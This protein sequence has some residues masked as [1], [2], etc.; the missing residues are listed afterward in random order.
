MTF[1]NY[2]IDVVIPL[3]NCTKIV[4]ELIMRISR[5]AQD[6]GLLINLI[7]IDDGSSDDTWNRVTNSRENAGIIIFAMKLS[8]NFGQ[9]SAILSGLL[10][11]TRQCVILMDG[12]LQDKPE[13]IPRFVNKFLEEGLDVVTGVLASNNNGLTSR[14][15]ASNI[16][17]RLRGKSG[18]ETSFRA[19]SNR[20]KVALLSEPETS[21]LSGPVIDSI[22]F[23]QGVLDIER[24]ERVHGTRYTLG[25]KLDL[26]VNF[27]LVKSRRAAYLFL[28]LAG[29]TG[30][31]SL[32]Y[33]STLMFQVVFLSKGLPAGL[34]QVVLLL[35][36]QMTFLSLGIAILILL[37]L[38]TLKFAT[39]A[40]DFH[41]M[42]TWKNH[43]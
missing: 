1:K 24:G 28:F 13:D 21:E 27:F 8:R 20:V 31:I 15:G 38:R 11:S 32:I 40:P 3:Y 4:D 41:I 7:L 42:E 37:S 34:N 14:L 36:T 9:H 23:K 26:A 35:T 5:I 18:R 33:A 25:R 2:E 30:T 29:L 17:H 12:D 6:S 19:I 39:K 43:E 22:G 16:F 10:H